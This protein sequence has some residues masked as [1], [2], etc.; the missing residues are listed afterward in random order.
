MGRP[1]GGALVNGATALL[2]GWRNHSSLLLS[3]NTAKGLMNQRESP[4]H[5]ASLLHL[6]LG[7]AA[8]KTVRNNTLSLVSNPVY[9]ILQKP[10]QTQR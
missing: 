8:S 6:D 5:T 7:L 1:E 10:K 9:G 4:Y 3:E 2:S